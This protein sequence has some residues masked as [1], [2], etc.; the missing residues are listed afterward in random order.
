MSSD[1]KLIFKC[2]FGSTVYGTRVPDSDTD[3]K[4][5][6][7]PSGRDILLQQVKENITQHTKIDVSKKNE[8]T[9]VDMEIF[10]FQQYL[11]LLM[12][13]QTVALDMLFTPEKH[14]L[15]LSDGDHS[16]EIW[17]EIKNNKD[18]LITSGV[19]AFFG[20]ARKQASKYGLR[21]GRVDAVK[22]TLEFL[23][24]YPAHDKLATHLFE[25]TQF[26]QPDQ[27]NVETDDPVI[28]LVSVDNKRG[29]QDVCLEVCGR[30]A[31]LTMNFKHAVEIFQKVFDQ[32]G[33]RSL[34]AAT[35]NNVDWKS[36]M[37]AVRVNCEA[38]E[39]LS[40]GHITFP[41]PEADTLLKIRKGEMPYQAVSEIIESGLIELK[42]CEKT[43]LL[44]KT[45][46]RDFAD[47]LILD[48][49]MDQVKG[50]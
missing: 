28:R 45:P 37:H 50:N 5:I 42:E 44:R 35:N 20:Y 29:G 10:S 47:A 25:I 1:K 17:R 22:R 19:G 21:G 27:L 6:Y 43:S 36:L 3:Y 2:E 7:I 31:P 18:K 30:K 26:A 15:P 46:D 38:K 13:G 32:Y 33:Q 48:A 39:L 40:T 24:K 16:S 9:D 8:S 41:R 34:Q 4:A 49:Y 12:E 11:K 23:N 14:Y